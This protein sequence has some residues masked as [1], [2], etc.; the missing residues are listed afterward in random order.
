MVGISWRV[1]PRRT[2]GGRE[3]QLCQAGWVIMA[4]YGNVQPLFRI[5][6][7]TQLRWCL[8]DSLG[9][10]CWFMLLF[11]RQYR[12]RYISKHSTFLLETESAAY[13]LIWHRFLADNEEGDSGAPNSLY[14]FYILD[15]RIDSF[16]SGSNEFN[17]CPGERTFLSSASTCH[18]VATFL[19][20]KLTVA[21]SFP[22][23]Y[24]AKDLSVKFKPIPYSEY[25]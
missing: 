6:I 8:N 2:V 14:L 7:W 5:I 21:N 10:C 4:Q 3:G 19:R 25:D 20:L 22:L 15:D 17:Y 11:W 24:A 16:A 9:A 18:Q 12:K 1:S 23:R 13:E